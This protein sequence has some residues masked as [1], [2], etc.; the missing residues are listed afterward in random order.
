MSKLIPPDKKRCQTEVTH[1]PFPFRMG[2][3]L[4]G[5]LYDVERCKNEPVAVAKEKKPGPDGKRGSMS[6]CGRCLDDLK[7]RPEFKQVTLTKV[8]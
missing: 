1:G 8:K 5:S 6:L 2:G 7:K 3:S 4:Y